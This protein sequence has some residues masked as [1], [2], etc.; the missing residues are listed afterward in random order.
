M[1]VEHAR[2]PARV[3][4]Q[5]Q[6]E[7]LR[8]DCVSLHLTAADTLVLAGSD[9]DAVVGNTPLVTG[10]LA[11]KKKV[12]RG[13]T[14]NLL[15]GAISG[16]RSGSYTISAFTR[17]GGETDMGNL[18]L[19]V[20]DAAVEELKLERDMVIDGAVDCMSGSIE[21]ELSGSDVTIAF[22]DS[23]AG[24]TLPIQALEVTLQRLPN[25]P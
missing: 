21:A 3:R 6:A 12:G 22:A 4:G 25:S 11:V 9:A 8:E 13:I 15:T 2:K 10:N 7:L 23:G 14:V 20:L 1:V 24:G 17:Y 16:L 19:K 5:G 18:A